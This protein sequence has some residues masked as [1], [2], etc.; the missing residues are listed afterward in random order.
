MKGTI[1]KCIE[2]LVTSKFGAPKWK[3]VLKTAGFS[4]FKLFSTMEDVPDGEVI[5]LIT[6]VSTVSGLPMT[7]VYEAF[8]EYWSTVYAPKVYGVYFSKAKS[9]REFLLSLDEIHVSMTKTIQNAHPP[10]FTYEQKGPN[11]LVMHYKSARGLVA[12]MPGLIAGLGKHFKD[13]PT[14]KVVGNDV[15]VHFA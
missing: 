12:L 6:A 10:R 7:A 1:A 11:D 8:G 2:E 14:A 13:R 9:T 15:H 3:E 4:D 5:K